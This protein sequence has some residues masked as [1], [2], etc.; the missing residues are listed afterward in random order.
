MQTRS[1]AAQRK[2]LKKLGLGQ[3]ARKRYPYKISNPNRHRMTGPINSTSIVRGRIFSPVPQEMNATLKYVDVLSGTASGINFLA[4]YSLN[5]LFDPEIT[6]TGHQPLGF[7]QYSTLYQQYRVN[8]AKIKVTAIA[9]QVGG[10]GNDDFILAVL[11][12]FSQ[13]TTSLASETLLE[14]DNVAWEWCPCSVD[15]NH[16]GS[17]NKSVEFYSKMSNYFGLPTI[18]PENNFVAGTGSNPSSNAWAAVQLNPQPSGGE[19]DY[20]LI[21]EITY[22]ATFLRPINLS[23][24]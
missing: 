11:P 3:G 6:G 24:S 9:G 12:N 16:T 20:S 13:Y 5:S 4:N 2:R 8:A 1:R 18:I 15:V 7:D 19:I 17:A 23:A 14:Q 21:V 10:T 22:Y